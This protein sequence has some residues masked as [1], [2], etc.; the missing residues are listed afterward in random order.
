VRALAHAAADLLLSDT[1]GPPEQRE[2]AYELIV[3]G[4]T[5]PPSRALSD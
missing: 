1:D 4:S 5:A 3:R 2:I